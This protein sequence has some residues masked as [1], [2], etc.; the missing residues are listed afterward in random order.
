MSP[1]RKWAH[2]LY[3]PHLLSDEL[4]W[5]HPCDKTPTLGEEHVAQEEDYYEE[6]D[7]V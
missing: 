1:H 3:S 4:L 7:E 5:A 2:A 6:F